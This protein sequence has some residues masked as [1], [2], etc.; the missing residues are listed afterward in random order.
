MFETRNSSVICRLKIFLR[1]V[2]IRFKWNSVFEN[3]KWT[4]AMNFALNL[5][6]EIEKDYEDIERKCKYGKQF[7]TPYKYD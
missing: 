1:R 5:D 3:I 2:K 7:L 6:Q 4:N